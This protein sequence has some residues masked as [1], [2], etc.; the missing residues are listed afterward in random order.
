MRQNSAKFG[1]D[2]KVELIKSFIIYCQISIKD[3]TKVGLNFVH[4]ERMKAKKTF[5]TKDQDLK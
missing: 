5:F 4:F 2:R 1:W 3:P